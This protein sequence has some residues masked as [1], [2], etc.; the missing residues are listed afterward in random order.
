MITKDGDNFQLNLWRKKTLILLK[1][2]QKFFLEESKILV[3]QFI[4][5]NYHF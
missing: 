5:K 3:T 2:F 4:W 1:K